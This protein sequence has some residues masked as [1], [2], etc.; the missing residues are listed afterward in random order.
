MQ[1]SAVDDEVANH[2]RDEEHTQAM[3]NLL[4]IF[5]L[6]LV[7]VRFV[8]CL[9]PRLSCRAGCNN[10]KSWPHL[11]WSVRWDLVLYSTLSWSLREFRGRGH[12]PPFAVQGLH[13]FNE[14][15]LLLV[16][17]AQRDNQIGEV[18]VLHAPAIV[19]VD[20][21]LKGGKPPVVHVESRPGNLADRRSLEVPDRAGMLVNTVSTQIDPR[22]VPIDA[23]IVEFLVAE[24]ETRVTPRAPAFPLKD[25]TASL[26]GIRDCLLVP[27]IV[28]PIRGTV[29]R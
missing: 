23:K 10:L 25:G 22:C 14:V 7:G 6:L 11:D 28:E 16:G 3:K 12:L 21:F 4:L 17:Q 18:R 24:I 20:D 1:Q 8:M 13:I 9:T 15:I 27:A 5:D 26:G 2:P 19:K 29:T